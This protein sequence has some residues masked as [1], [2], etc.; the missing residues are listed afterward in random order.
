MWTEFEW[1]KSVEGWWFPTELVD[2][3]VGKEP[4]DDSPGDEDSS[5]SVEATSH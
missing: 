4:E 2:E 1:E 5:G 3:E